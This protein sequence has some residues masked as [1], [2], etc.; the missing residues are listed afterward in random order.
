MCVL[1]VTPV[2]ETCDVRQAVYAFWQYELCDVFIEVSKPCFAAAVGS[3]EALEQSAVRE[4]LW[5]SL[6]AGLRFSISQITSEIPLLSLNLAH[7]FII[8]VEQLNDKYSTCILM[9]HPILLHCTLSP[10]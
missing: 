8:L 3:P 5:I 2:I 4:T 9:K 7:I 1:I 10:I 6:D